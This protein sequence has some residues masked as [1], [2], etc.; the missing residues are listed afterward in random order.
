MYM[1]VWCVCGGDCSKKRK[2]EEPVPPAVKKS[3]DE[4]KQ[5]TALKVRER[6]KCCFFYHIS[7]YCFPQKQNKEIW[8]VR[9][10]LKASLSNSDLK[11]LLMA[12]SQHIP[13]GES[14]VYTSATLL[15]C[16]DRQ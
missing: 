8:R 6:E 5:E 3:K 7:V 12:N 15:V 2:A 13:I 11:A 9:D 4:V 14:K 10:E 16:V 1:Y